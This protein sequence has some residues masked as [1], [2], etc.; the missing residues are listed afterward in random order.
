MNKR[1]D[2]AITM[3]CLV[4]PEEYTYDY[5]TMEDDDEDIEEFIEKKRQEYYWE[6]F[7]YVNDFE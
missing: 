4:P 1:F 5:P 2:E 3:G 7:G 6:W